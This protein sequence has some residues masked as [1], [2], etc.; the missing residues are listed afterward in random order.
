MK[1]NFKCEVCGADSQYTLSTLTLCGA[2]GT[3]FDGE[4]LKLHICPECCN[5]I[6]ECITKKA[7]DGTT[8][9]TDETENLYY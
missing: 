8:T 1:D 3:Y 5:S 4:K 9:E 7:T 2:Y 6:I